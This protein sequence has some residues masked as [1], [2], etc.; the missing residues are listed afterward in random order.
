MNIKPIN[1]DV[2]LKMLLLKLTVGA[3][4]SLVIGMIVKEEIKVLDDAEEKLIE[5]KQQKQ[6][7]TESES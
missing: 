6:N 3:L 2:K 7:D 5:R 1:V 4:T